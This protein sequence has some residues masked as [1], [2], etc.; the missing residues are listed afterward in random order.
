MHQAGADC[1]QKS[2][3]WN[4]SIVEAPPGSDSA[5]PACRSPNE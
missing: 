2:R 4:A 5:Q 1:K 3:G